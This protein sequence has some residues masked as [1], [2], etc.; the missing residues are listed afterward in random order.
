MGLPREDRRNFGIGFATLAAMMAAHALTETARDALFLSRLDASLLPWAYLAI[1]GLALGVVRL[2]QRMLA[3][4]SDKRVLLAGS[5]VVAAGV[6]ALFGYLL[7]G[8]VDGTRS[9]ISTEVLFGLYIWS[10]LVATVVVVQFW[11]LLDDAV[12]VTQAKRIFGPVAAG[13]VFGATLG[14]F[15]AERL[16]V[17]TSPRYLLFAAAVFLLV[18]SVFPFLWRREELQEEHSPKRRTPVAEGHGVRTL[19]GHVYLRRLLLLVLLSTVALTV[20]DFLFK[21]IVADA[22]TDPDELAA[23]FARFYIVLNGAGLMVQLF[24]SGW[25]LRLVGV[26]RVLFFLPA[27]L[28][29]GAGGLAVAPVLAPALLLKGADGSLRHSLHRTGMEVLYLPVP[30]ELRDR[31]KGLIDGVGQ[32]GGQAVASL[33]IVGALAVELDLRA[34][35]GV[36]V[37]LS[38]G[39]LLVLR[40][41]KG[42]YLDLFRQS[43]R[44][45]SLESR[46]GSLVELDLHSLEGLLGGL[47]SEV[48]EE[49]LVALELFERY[50]KVH[51]IP[52]LVIYHPSSEV[53][54][55]A[56]RIFASAK[57]ESVV[58]LVRRLLRSSKPELRAGALRTITAI[59]PDLELLEDALNNTDPALHSTA[60]ISMLHRGHGDAAMLWPQLERCVSEGTQEVREGLCQAIAA[61]RAPEFH[62]QLLLLLGDRQPSVRRAALDAMA[63]VPDERN[64]ELL[65]PLLDQGNLR[66]LAR[67]ALLAIGEPARLAL[68]EVLRD[69]KLPR[70]LRRHVPLTLSRFPQVQK[71]ADQLSEHLAGERDGAVRFKLLRAL[72][73][74]A[75]AG[76]T[77]D[78]ELLEGL[79]RK[80]LLRIVELLRMRVQVRRE[81]ERLDA[82]TTDDAEE[83][84]GGELLAATL[85][86]KEYNAL[87]RLFRIRGLLDPAESW[88]LL[89]RGLRD[90]GKLVRA[91][92]GELLEN[93]LRG[94]TRDAILALTG[95]APTEERM[96][97]AA[98]ALGVSLPETLPYDE[99]LARFLQD[100]SEAVRSIAAY[101]IGE[102]GLVELRPQLE[103]AMPSR[104]GAVRDVMERAIAALMPP[105]VA[106]V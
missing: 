56:M 16:L 47:N 24:V 13:G 58:P 50:D 98:Q 60:I 46:G 17:W 38:F 74:V 57:D 7:G 93:A 36:L 73:D 15:A 91:A 31:Y 18:G 70:S 89:W 45:G 64:I 86:E 34:L 94:P 95:E 29:L 6:A 88:P 35:A 5:L 20:A 19:C 14:S 8:R 32:R 21:S 82:L 76:A 59:A 10:G 53:S 12:T 101:H 72:D 62:E 80:H 106:R 97:R 42:P 23:F 52:K 81:L 51:V 61:E 2:N 69:P 27:L 104:R 92:S 75:R 37:V 39:W 67:R 33:A 103:E 55:A 71:V 41:I 54:L 28:L 87:E 77:L 105:E 78:R 30:R 68:G 90:N 99:E 9:Q 79:S 85:K 84:L 49:V 26:N 65:V 83:L 3:K 40:G 100:P 66:S 4:S 25:L 44:G 22:Y 63:E 43:L 1:A 11:L 48:D 96:R 102:L